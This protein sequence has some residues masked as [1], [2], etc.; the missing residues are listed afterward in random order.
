MSAFGDKAIHGEIV[1][2]SCRSLQIILETV[3]FSQPEANC[4]DT[5]HSLCGKV[6]EYSVKELCSAT[7]GLGERNDFVAYN[8]F[9]VHID[10]ATSIINKFTQSYNV[11]EI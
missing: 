2:K 6:H 1:L 7:L 9:F 8:G 4:L 5:L 11:S 10:S 3:N